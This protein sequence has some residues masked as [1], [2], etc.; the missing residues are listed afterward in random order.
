MQ[1]RSYTKQAKQSLDLTQLKPTPKSRPA[2]E[3]H[4]DGALVDVKGNPWHNPAKKYVL[5]PMDTQ[6]PFN[7][8]YYESI[9]YTIENCDPDGPRIRLGTAVKMGQPLEWRGNYLLS[10]SAER[11]DEI[12]RN[13]PTGNTG[14]A[15]YDK[16]MQKV[17][18]N[19]LEEPVRVR[20]MTEKVDISDLVQVG[21]PEFRE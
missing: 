17:K 2:H 15:Y 13:G 8:Q 19:Q 5:A 9:G 20:G 11:S 16:L 4:F 18:A 14:Q 21:I 6:H 10:C 3:A 1:K 7:F 12:F